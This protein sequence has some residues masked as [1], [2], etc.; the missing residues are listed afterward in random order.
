MRFDSFV[1]FVLPDNG[2]IGGGE[3]FLEVERRRLVSFFLTDF[4]VSSLVFVRRDN[5]I[6]REMRLIVIKV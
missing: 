1:P 4:F 5:G 3:F 2:I 6:E